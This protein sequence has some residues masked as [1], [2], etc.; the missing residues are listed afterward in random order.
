MIRMTR[1]VMRPSRRSMFLAC[2]AWLACFSSKA[3]VDAS[4]DNLPRRRTEEAILEPH[5]KSKRVLV[6]GAAGFVGS[7][8][9]DALLARGDT[10]IIMDEVNDY[11]NVSIKEAN[12]RYLEE[13]HGNKRLKIYRGDV[14][15]E[16]FV[17]MVFAAENPKWVCHLAARAGV[18]PSIQNPFIYVHSNVLGTTRLMDAAVRY[19]VRNFV[20]A[21]SSS[22]YG[23]SSETFFDEDQPVDHP[24]S[25]YAATKKIT[26]LFAY[27]WR[28]LYR[29]PITGLRFF[30]VYGPRG[31]PDMAPFIFVDRVSRGLSLPQYGNGSSS[32]DYTYIDDIVDG[33]IR[34]ID[35][36]YMYK[37]FNLGKGSGTELSEFI[38]IV[39][40]QVNETAK[41]EY[42]PDQPGDVPYTCANVTKAK[43]LLGYE[44]HTKFEAGMAKTVEWYKQAYPLA[45]A[46]KRK[47]NDSVN[48]KPSTEAT[49]DRD[50]NQRRRLSLPLP[51]V[52]P[53]KD[54]RHRFLRQLQE[55]DRLHDEFDLA[56]Q[57]ETVVAPHTGPKK[58]MVT[59]AAGFIGSHVADYLLSRGDE[60]VV[61]DEVNDYYDVAIKEKN[62]QLLLDK[63]GKTN[64]LKIYRGD[65]VNETLMDEIFRTEKP[66]WICHLAARAGV[67]PSIDDPYV[68]IHS[69]VVGTTRLLSLAK[70]YGV[71]NF[72]FARSSSVYGGSKSIFFSEEE[73]VIHPI[74]PYAASKKS[75]ELLGYT[76]HHLY[77]IPVTGLRFFTVYGPR[78]RPDMA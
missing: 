35:R 43:T 29:L 36:P 37:I 38:R 55:I 46:K 71:E 32:R 50:T 23:G 74:S 1:R 14:A 3:G 25:P 20:Y 53:P 69:N 10:V 59:G 40:E 61:V 47:K 42:L 5:S 64:R 44:P 65:I 6:T 21:S 11:Y 68:Y 27:T 56:W 30:T 34:S 12:L 28:Y 9:A 33:V 8:V 24:I 78:G 13:K 7:H 17:D 73:S 70:E 75:C 62:L 49:E 58:V 76:F 60:V 57:N 39:E 26:E 45:D 66:K 48:D 63:H 18:R 19:K 41:I 77:N 51:V 67:R 2:L 16:T 52:G 4:S 22:V 54:T 72:V 31:R 15:N